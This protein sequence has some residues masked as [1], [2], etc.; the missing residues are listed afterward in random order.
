MATKLNRMLA[1]LSSAA[2]SRR[3]GFPLARDSTGQLSHFMVSVLSRGAPNSHR[4]DTSGSRAPQMLHRRA[5]FMRGPYRPRITTGST[6]TVRPQSRHVI[7]AIWRPSGMAPKGRD[8]GAARPCST[9]TVGVLHERMKAK[10]KPCATLD[11][12]GSF[13]VPWFAAED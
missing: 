2:R 13:V 4:V 6:S 5:R 10:N 8:D 11:L 9:A 7:R 3:L 1:R 12:Q